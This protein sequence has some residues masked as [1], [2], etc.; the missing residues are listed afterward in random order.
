MIQ[1][2]INRQIMSYVKSLREPLTV[3]LVQLQDA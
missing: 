3:F 2:K 1:K